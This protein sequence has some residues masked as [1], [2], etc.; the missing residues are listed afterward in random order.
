MGIKVS[1]RQVGDI[2]IIDL[3]GRMIAGSGSQQI[4]MALVDEFDRGHKWLLL[5]CAD[6]TFVDSSGIGDILASH[7]AIIRRG[8]VVRLLN[9]TR[10]LRDSLERT[11]LDSV[12]DV[13]HDETAALASFNDADNER[14]QQKLAVYLQ[15]AQ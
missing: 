2:T 13:F 6:V 11:R 3:S 4:L 1:T 8:G 15:R 10:T 12:L 5:N 14:T 9:P 7:A